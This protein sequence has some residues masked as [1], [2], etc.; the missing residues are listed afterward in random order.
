MIEK[1]QI[2]SPVGESF[3]NISRQELQ[4]SISESTQRKLSTGLKHST[5]DRPSIKSRKPPTKNALKQ[6][7]AYSTKFTLE[8]IAEIKASQP[9]PTPTPEEEPAPVSTNKLLRPKGAAGLLAQ[10]GAPDLSKLKKTKKTT[11]EPPK[12]EEEPPVQPAQNE[13]P[14]LS[15]DDTPNEEPAPK[16]YVPPKGAF[17]MLGSAAPDLTK[18]KKTRKAEDEEAN[19]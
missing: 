16:K 3:E 17:N 18:L 8:E 19:Q 14:L 11:E 15:L 13:Q 10:M 6:G 2:I 12:T 9:E 4:D 1:D 7:E 5:L